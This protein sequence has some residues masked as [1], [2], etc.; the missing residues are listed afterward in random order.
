MCGACSLPEQK[1]VCSLERCV[2]VGLQIDQTG[3]V[4]IEPG[5]ISSLAAKG[6]LTAYG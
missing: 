3:L 4:K 1:N 2:V 5:S 6:S